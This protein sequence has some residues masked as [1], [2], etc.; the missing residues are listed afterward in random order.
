M[1]LNHMHNIDGF[2]VLVLLEGH[3]FFET[4]YP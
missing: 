3:C 1:Y 2:V 4:F